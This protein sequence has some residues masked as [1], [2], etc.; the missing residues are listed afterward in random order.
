MPTSSSQMTAEGWRSKEQRDMFFRVIVSAYI[1]NKG[2]LNWE[3]VYKKAKE[4]VD[5]TFKIYPD[6][7][8]NG[9]SNRPDY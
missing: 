6:P 1:N 3:E 2:D 7:Q 5:T 9:K 8:D 4:I